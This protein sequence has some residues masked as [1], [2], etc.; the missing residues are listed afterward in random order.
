MGFALGDM[1]VTDGA[2]SRP[3]SMRSWR[4]PIGE[5]ARYILEEASKPVVIH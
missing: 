4:S 3:G 5:A 2:R 1:F